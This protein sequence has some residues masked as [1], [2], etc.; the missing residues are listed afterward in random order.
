MI[1]LKLLLG[2]LYCFLLI[3]LLGVIFEI[4]SYQSLVF[5]PQSLF[6]FIEVSAILI[7]KLANAP[8]SNTSANFGFLSSKK[9]LFDVKLAKHVLNDRQLCYRN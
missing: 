2:K 5:L 9:S 6:F 4:L 8:C 3:S 1:I 7:S